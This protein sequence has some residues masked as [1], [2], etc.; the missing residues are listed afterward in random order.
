MSPKHLIIS[1]VIIVLFLLSSCADHI[2]ES[3]PSIDETIIQVPVS[4]TFTEIQS[5][6]FNKSCAFSGCHVSGSIAPDLS[7]NS[8]DRIVGKPGSTGLNYIEPNN[9]TQ[10]YL[11]KKILGEGISGS[12]MPI[13]SSPLSQSVI[14]SIT[15]WINDGAKNN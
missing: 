3:T 4:T 12:G 14:D 9:P 2:V 13:R 7:N 1:I 6:V 5:N 10:S 11:L 15:T 8:Y